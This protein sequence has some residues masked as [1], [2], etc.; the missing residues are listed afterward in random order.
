N[1]SNNTVTDTQGVCI[2]TSAFGIVTS[3]G[4]MNNNN[5]TSNSNVNGQPGF[6]VGADQHFAITDNP[7]LTITIDGNTTPPTHANGILASVRSSNGTLNAKIINNN[8]AAPLGGVRPGIRV[9]SGNNTAGENAT[10][11]LNISGNTSAGSG[12]TQGIGLRKQGTST[13][14]NVFSINAL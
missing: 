10:V 5:V 3:S 9:D 12:G 4:V 14:V 11:C 8:I 2:A 7:T 13:S 1:I 6:A